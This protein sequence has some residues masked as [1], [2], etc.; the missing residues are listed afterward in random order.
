MLNIFTVHLNM[1]KVSKIQILLILKNNNN[2]LFIS[3]IETH[4]G[5]IRES[6]TFLSN[7]H[8]LYKKIK[9]NDY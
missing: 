7:L 3:N 5:H 1:F 8:K 2:K 4:Y 9:L 6:I